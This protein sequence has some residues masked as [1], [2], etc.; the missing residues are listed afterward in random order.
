MVQ[1]LTVILS[2]DPN[3]YLTPIDNKYNIYSFQ[4]Q[5]AATIASFVNRYTDTNLELPNADI[6]GSTNENRGLVDRLLADAKNMLRGSFNENEYREVLAI[7]EQASQR[8]LLGANK[9]YD[10]CLG[11]VVNIANET[12][13]NRDLDE[14]ELST[15]SR[16]PKALYVYIALVAVELI[17]A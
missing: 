15:I 12:L 13:R 10:G 14:M 2:I 3:L 1:Q 17:S 4:G 8:G 7:I 11:E 6:M 16:Q 9:S 5:D